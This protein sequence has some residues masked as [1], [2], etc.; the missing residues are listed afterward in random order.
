MNKKLSTLWPRMPCSSLCGYAG[1]MRRPHFSCLFC[2][3]RRFFYGKMDPEKY[4]YNSLMRVV[5]PEDQTT[6]VLLIDNNR[7]N[8]KVKAA[9]LKRL[10]TIC[11]WLAN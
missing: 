10:L 7:R 5:F 4:H 1:K 2:R 8:A 3:V 6:Y 9:I 11:E